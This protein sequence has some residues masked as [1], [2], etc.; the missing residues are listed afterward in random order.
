MLLELKEIK[1]LVPVKFYRN[2]VLNKLINFISLLPLRLYIF[3][4][5]NSYNRIIFQKSDFMKSYE[6]LFAGKMHLY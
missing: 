1:F 3:L 4:L 5:C 6:I 2:V